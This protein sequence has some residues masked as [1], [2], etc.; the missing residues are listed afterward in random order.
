[1]PPLLAIIAAIPRAAVALESIAKS[2]ET[3]GQRIKEE[4]AAKRRGEKDEM[5]DSAINLALS[6]G[7]RD[8]EERER[9][10]LDF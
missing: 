8:E 4:Q 5:V 1:M 2:L 7:M 10:S 6:G 3:I 9:E